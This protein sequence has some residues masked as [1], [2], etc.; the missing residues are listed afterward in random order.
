MVNR[1]TKYWFFTAQRKLPSKEKLIPG[2]KEKEIY[3]L[4]D[5]LNCLAQGYQKENFLKQFMISNQN[6]D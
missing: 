4:K 6:K 2:V 5:V 1:N 3:T